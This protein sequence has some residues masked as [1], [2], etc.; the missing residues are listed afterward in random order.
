[1]LFKERKNILEVY[2][3]LFANA[4]SVKLMLVFSEFTR[5]LL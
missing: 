5:E 2:V 1:M 3:L 4:S